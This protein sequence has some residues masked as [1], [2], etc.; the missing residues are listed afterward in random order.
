MPFIP[1]KRLLSESPELK[2]TKK[3]SRLNSDSTRNTENTSTVNPDEEINIE[4]LIKTELQTQ[5]NTNMPPKIEKG[6]K[7]G[8]KSPETHAETK[9]MRLDADAM[10]KIVAEVVS[11]LI[12]VLIKAIT[13]AIASCMTNTLTKQIT[14]IEDEQSVQSQY[15]QQQSLNALYERDKLEQYD[16]RLNIR[17]NGV[18]EKEQEVVEELVEQVCAAA[19]A[20]MRKEDISACHWIGAKGTTHRAIICRFISRQTQSRVMNKKK[21]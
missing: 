16:R 17:I 14:K 9:D 6:K 1:V 13:T 18:E 20:P 21:I 10:A 15:I 12:P 11:Q 7:G 8:Q 19:K 2:N 5:L 3:H 4:D